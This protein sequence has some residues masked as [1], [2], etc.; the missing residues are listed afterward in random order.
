VSTLIDFPLVIARGGLAA[1]LALMTRD[2]GEYALA[3][4]TKQD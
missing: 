2:R 3:F 4:R 1:A